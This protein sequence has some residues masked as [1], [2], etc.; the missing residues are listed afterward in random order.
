MDFVFLVHNS[1]GPKIYYTEAEKF[2]HLHC[3]GGS[4]I[5]PEDPENGFVVRLP[6][7]GPQAPSVR[8]SPPDKTAGTKS[9]AAAS[10]I[11]MAPHRLHF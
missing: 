9:V 5:G 6:A 10:P 2:A 1:E 8:S 3:R 11:P 7:T 4:R